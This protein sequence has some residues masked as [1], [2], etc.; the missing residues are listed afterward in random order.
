MTLINRYLP[1]CGS[2]GSRILLAG[3]RIDE[4]DVVAPVDDVVLL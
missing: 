4:E 2:F 3:N 1:T